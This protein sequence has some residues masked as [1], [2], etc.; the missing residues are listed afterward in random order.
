M[1]RPYT[2][3]PKPN[4]NS[5]LPL[6]PDSWPGQTRPK[7]ILEKNI[8]QHK[9]YQEN[10]LNRTWSA[11]NFFENG[12]VH[13]DKL[14]TW[15]ETGRQPPKEQSRVSSL[16]STPNIVI[17]VKLGDDNY[18]FESHR[19]S[20]AG[21]SRFSTT[22]RYSS[23]RKERLKAMLE[24]ET[25][26]HSHLISQETN[27]TKEIRQ[28]QLKL[29]REKHAR[30]KKRKEQER[31]AKA[32][33]LMYEQFQKN[34]PELRDIESSRLQNHVQTVW[35]DQVEDKNMLKVEQEK[36]R[37]IEKENFDR[38][39]SERKAE[40]R[41]AKLKSVESKKAIAEAL[42]QQLAELKAKNIAFK[43]LEQEKEA[44]IIEEENLRQLED[45]R[46]ALIKRHQNQKHAKLLW[47]QWKAQLRQRTAERQRELHVEKEMLEKLIA[48]TARADTSRTARKEEMRL[49]ILENLKTVRENLKSEKSLQEDLDLMIREKGE[50][51]WR[52]R[53]A[54]WAKQR[55]ASE[56]LL[57]S[58]LD[59]Q[60]R[61][62]LEKIKANK[63]KQ[64]E[65]LLEKENLLNEIELIKVETARSLLKKS[66]EKKTEQLE[67]EVEI[68]EKEL[69]KI[70][71]KQ[72]EE[73]QDAELF[74]Q[75]QAY[76]GM[77][78]SARENMNDE[79]F[80][81]RIYARPSTAGSTVRFNVPEPELSVSPL[82]GVGSR[83]TTANSGVS[84]RTRVT[85]PFIY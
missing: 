44:F 51:I 66:E 53:E 75:H 35:K 36:M 6:A 14:D 4:R 73:L 20:T 2:A 33:Q 82:K 16:V 54:T 70:A 37:E 81:E 78:E 45:K 18:E 65:T 5:S 7:S 83:P 84:I 26:S 72:D 41:K 31:K 69:E 19:P 58:V 80:I 71:I 43:K 38:M 9:R 48:E 42:G 56:K 25:N 50:E 8:V 57:K 34:C 1:Q 47:R 21:S 60:A 67:R 59:E 17:P 76:K 68:K 49:E 40:E 11:H 63:I 27:S 52:E 74:Q 28:K 3:A 23:E 22:S 79:P 39:E 85:G 32:A 29:L 61:Q 10:R 77:V 24:E 62:M 46:A 12:T 30:Y 55:E 64:A 15:G 13:A